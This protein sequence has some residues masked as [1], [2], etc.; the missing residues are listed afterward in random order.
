MPIHSA[1]SNS[2]HNLKL[3]KKGQCK[4]QEKMQEDTPCKPILSKEEKTALQV[5]KSSNEH[6]VND[7]PQL[8]MEGRVRV[9][10]PEY[11]QT[12][13]QSHQCEEPIL[14]TS[15]KHNL[16]QGSK[17]HSESS[18]FTKRSKLVP[19]SEFNVSDAVKVENNISFITR[20]DV[21]PSPIL[22]FAHDEH[23]LNEIEMPIGKESDGNTLGLNSTLPK[24]PI[25]LVGSFAGPNNGV[26]LTI[27][28]ITEDKVSQAGSATASFS[29]PYAWSV[30]SQENWKQS[31]TTLDSEQPGTNLSQKFSSKTGALMQSSTRIIDQGTNLDVEE[32]T[33]RSETRFQNTFVRTKASTNMKLDLE[34]QGHIQCPTH[35][36]KLLYRNAEERRDSN[37]HK[38]HFGNTN[39]SKKMYKSVFKLMDEVQFPAAEKKMQN[40]ASQNSPI[41]SDGESRDKLKLQNILIPLSVKNNNLQQFESSDPALKSTHFSPFY[42]RWFYKGEFG[43]G[44]GKWNLTVPEGVDLNMVANVHSEKRRGSPTPDQIQTQDE[45]V[46]VVKTRKDIHLPKHFV[47][48]NP[49]TRRERLADDELTVIDVFH[50]LRKT[51]EFD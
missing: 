40:N 7:T 32:W 1:T 43:T 14:N 33:K 13:P 36:E 24:A 12:L 20:T 26:T 35:S 44:F 51:L 19:D 38:R 41:L 23:K 29:W 50:N 3:T 30:Q 4:L 37:L 21:T 8:E 17:H 42:S 22:I 31:T 45:G 25:S 10:L 6:K 47:K 2:L 49:P 28:T 34:P 18:Q 46:T 48:L 27:N 15:Q 16:Q 11:Q 39:Y 9:E 5:S